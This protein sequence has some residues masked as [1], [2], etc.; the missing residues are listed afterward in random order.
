MTRALLALSLLVV[1]VGLPAGS[2]SAAID[3]ELDTPQWRE[4]RATLFGTRPIRE[5]AEAVI[6]L[7]V[8][9]RPDSGALVPVRV[10]ARQP[11]S[12]ARFV[13]RIAVVI[14]RNPEPLA[15]L[16]HLTPESGQADLT[17]YMRVETHSPLRAVAELS[18]GTLFMAATLVKAS[19]GCAAP[20]VQLTLPPDH[21]QVRLTTQE[22]VALNEPNWARIM[23]THPN[24]TGLQSNPVTRHP[25]SAHY[26]TRVTVTLDGRPVLVAETTIASSEDP[27][28]RFYFTPTRPGELRAEVKDSRGAT[29]RNS[30]AVTPN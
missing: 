10:R 24:H 29:F 2:P 21:G 17:T 7:E 18:D 8:P 13:K 19:G 16:F 9:V 30:L 3:P 20:P 28:F 27:S 26:V 12:P 15:A 23:V 6:Q 11:Q 25:I 5:D 4:L 1:L 14:D 22:R